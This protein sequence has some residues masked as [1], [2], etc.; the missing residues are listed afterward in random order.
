M[1]GLYRVHQFS[2]VELF[3]IAD[4]DGRGDGEMGRVG[5]V[6]WMK[7]WL[8]RRR[9]V[10]SWGYIIGGCGYDITTHTHT[11]RNLGKREILTHSHTLTSTH[12]YSTHTH[13]HTHTHRVLEMP[14]AELGSPAHRKYDIEVWMPGRGGYGEVTSASDC[15]S[16]QSQRLGITTRYKGERSYP[17]TVSCTF[18]SSPF[19]LHPSPII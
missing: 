1:R 3:V 15:T 12:T 8:F 6:C 7:W 10:Q 17:H 19:T 4:G 5:E 11:A 13:T 9:S 14:T 2:K 18:F 16:F